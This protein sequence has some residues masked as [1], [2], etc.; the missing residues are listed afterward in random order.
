[1]KNEQIRLAVVDDH[2]VFREGVV[3]I[4]SACSDMEVVAQGGSAKEALELAGSSDVDI[5]I[6]DISIPGGGIAALQG[7]IA[8][9]IRSRVIMLT[10][11]AN[12]ADVAQ[13]LRL[14]AHGYVVKGDTG[15]D[16]LHAVR[17]VH[18]GGLYLSPSLGAR[19][20][21]NAPCG[22]VAAP[23]NSRSRLNSREIEI[24]SLVKLG[25]SNK[26]IGKMLNLSDKTI[27]YYMT[28]LFHKLKVRNRVEA[29]VMGMPEEP[30][31]SMTEETIE[32]DWKSD[33]QRH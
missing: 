24:L 25:H 26:A 33:L 13:S 20:V 15:P 5:I 6:L 32:P 28:H 12:Q 3:Q 30:A 7:V 29:A 23:A 2:P 22:N 19:I 4:V 18:G 27:K 10:A 14:G 1:M 31:D 8:M 16:L 21:A 17:S 9:G 11:S